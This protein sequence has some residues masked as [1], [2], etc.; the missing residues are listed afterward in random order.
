[1]L[2]RLPLVIALLLIASAASA[3][4]IH[5]RDGSVVFGQILSLENGEDLVVDT[6]YMDEVT[7]EWEAIESIEQGR[8][9][10][11][12]LFNGRRI[13]GAIFV[14]EAGVR[15]GGKDS[16]R[17]PI[18]MSRVFQIEEFNQTLWDGLNVFTDLGMNIV[19]G[20]NTVTQL[21]V[22]AGVNYDG[23]KFETGIDASA[24]VNEQIEAPDTRRETLNAYYTYLLRENWTL[25]GLYTFEADEQQGLQGRSLAGATVGNR[26]VNNRR[27]RLRLEAGLVVNSEDFELADRT[28][29]LEGVIGSAVRWRSKHD[30]DLDA[31]LFI[32]PNLEQ[33]G[34]TRATF[35][36][37]LSVDLIGDLD[38]KL[39]AYSRYDSDPPLDNEKND[40]GTTV[41]LSWDWD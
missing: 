34:R 3:A 29:S 38:F 26:I 30:I 39:T 16:K 31:S 37:S 12:E 4:E 28:E 40:W 11:V 36:A 8:P 15:I 19:R 25:G 20:N 21:T 33:S 1:M 41:G 35:D 22:A 5:L 27:F 24:I 6:E 9:V 17:E 14:D 18:P 13:T 23:P 10:V 32:L 7:I 2:A